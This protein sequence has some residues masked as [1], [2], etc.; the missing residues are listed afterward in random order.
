MDWTKAKTILIIA[1]LATNVT[2]L[3]VY[4]L[5]WKQRER[6]DEGVIFEILEAANVRIEAELPDYPK[7]MAVLYVRPQPADHRT[8]M[9]I[10]ANQAAPERE[11]GQGAEPAPGGDGEAGA[12]GKEPG[13]DGPGEAEID[14]AV[15][16]ADGVMRECGY[17]TENARRILPVSYENGKILIKYRNVYDNIPIEES[18]AVCE[19][20][21]GRVMSLE[22]KWYMP[23]ELHDKKGEI[24]GPAEAMIML[25]P[26]KDESE[27]MSIKKVELVYWVS[28]EGAGVESPVAD[29]ALPAWK[30]TDGRGRETYIPA[31][32]QR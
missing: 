22:R 31:Y 27:A 29:T 25:L 6:V 21:N 24:M 30:I 2:L 23:V 1:L 3:A 11:G 4:S 10:L 8:I 5:E 20:E 16:A 12:D 26:D 19:V 18:S 7:R 14:A 9:E 28:P 17:L 13:G 15:A 32:R